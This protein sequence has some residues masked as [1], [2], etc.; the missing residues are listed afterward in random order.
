M[1]NTSDTTDLEKKQKEVLS[2]ESLISQ[3]ISK[4][5]NVETMEKLLSMRRELKKEWAREQFTKSMAAL[6][7]KIPVIPK[8][9]KVRFVSKRTGSVTSYS[10]APLDHIVDVAKGFISD[11]GFAYTILSS[12]T[13][14]SVSATVVVSHVDGHSEETGFSVPIDK[15]SSMNP[16]QQHVSA[17]S[18]AKRCAFCNAFGILTGG[19]DT[20]NDP[21]DINLPT[22]A[23]W[24]QREENPPTKNEP[25]EDESITFSQLTRIKQSIPFTKLPKILIKMGVNAAE[26]LTKDQ[27]SQIIKRFYD[28]TLITWLETEPNDENEEAVVLEKGKIPS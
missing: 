22:S 18:Y 12:S 28:R 26:D 20:P 23:K 21:K 7:K 11:S 13:D 3:A 24:P 1:K 6:Q 5:V 8:N 15:E 10:Y 4:G 19:E 16:Q 17:S 9:R 2:P 14:T 27:A 25:T